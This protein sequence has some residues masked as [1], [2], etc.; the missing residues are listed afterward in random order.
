M[1]NQLKKLALG[2]NWELYGNPEKPSYILEFVL[3]ICSKNTTLGSESLET[4]LEMFKAYHKVFLRRPDVND[5]HWPNV[6]LLLARTAILYDRDNIS[7]SDGIISLSL[8]KCDLTIIAKAEIL[9][10]GYAASLLAEEG[11]FLIKSTSTFSNC[12]SEIEKLQNLIVSVVTKVYNRYLQTCEAV[13]CI[14]DGL[15]LYKGASSAM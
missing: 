8:R 6:A 2:K 4:L 14:L 13:Q 1:E 10:D 7:F 5:S 15:L 9:F 11:H 12:A 3:P